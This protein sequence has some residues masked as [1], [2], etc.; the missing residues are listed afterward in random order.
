MKNMIPIVSWHNM[1]YKESIELAYR[2]NKNTNKQNKKY[3]KNY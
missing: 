3:N 2:K 1:Q